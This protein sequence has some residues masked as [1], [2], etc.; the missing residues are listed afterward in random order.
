[1]SAR[2]V[3]SSME[4]FLSVATNIATGGLVGYENGKG[5]RDGFLSHMLNEGLGEITGRNL[6]REQANKAGEAVQ[7]EDAARR[8]QMLNE[9]Q[10]R[11]AEDMMASSGARAIRN[12]S[13]MGGGR[14]QMLSAETSD[15][16]DF[17]GL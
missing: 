9:Q 11:Q 10:Q 6:A 16:T 3:S 4:D 1:M 2:G 14:G 17:L 12:S 15:E 13:A 8:T 7:R 5:F